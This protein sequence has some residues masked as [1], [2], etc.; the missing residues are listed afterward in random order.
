MNT[1]ELKGGMMNII[2]RVEDEAVLTQMFEAIT[3]IIV[4]TYGQISE[5]SPEQVVELE[6]AIEETY[7]PDNLVDHDEVMKNMTRWLKK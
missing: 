7:N 1:L 2:S 6:L 5:L 4:E 3:E